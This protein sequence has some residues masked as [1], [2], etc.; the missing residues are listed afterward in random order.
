MG[1]FRVPI[2]IGDRQGT[3]WEPV[4]AHVDSGATYTWVPAH[5]LQNLGVE[6]TERWE[7]ETTNGEV[8]DRD[9]AQ[10][11]V[12]YDGQAHITWVAFAAERDA[13]LL[14]AY[15]LEGFRLAVDPVNQQLVPVRALAL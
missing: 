2:E 15:T 12:R 9:M 13:P 1:T 8:I 3:R 7:F 4:M 14:G 10:T 5:I 11:W 6:P